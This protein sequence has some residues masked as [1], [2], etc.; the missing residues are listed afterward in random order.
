MVLTGI[1]AAS[2]LVATSSAFAAFT[3]PRLFASQH[4]VKNRV[5]LLYT[6]STADDPVAKIVHYI[7]VPYKTNLEARP[8]GTLVGTVVLR[9]NLS[10]RVVDNTTGNMVL[11]GTITAVRADTQYTVNG[12]TGRMSEAA[13]ACTGKPLNEFGQYWLL[14]LKDAGGDVAWDVPAFAERRSAATV[15]GAD[16]TV[17]VCFAP[18]DV[19]ATSPNRTPG[20]FKVRELDLRLTKVFTSPKDGLQRFSTLATP[21]TPKTGRVNEGGT[22]EAQSIVSYPRAVSIAKPVRV[23]LTNGYATFRFGGTVSTPPHDRGR[24]SL[25]R[26]FNRTD[27]GGRTAKA[28]KIRESGRGNYTRL[29]TIKR[30]PKAQN[31]WFQ[32][33]SYV[34]TALY[35]EKGCA[36]N[37]HPGI[38]CIQTTRAGYMV[39]SRNVMVRVPAT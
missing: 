38:T 28:F 2:A 16:A 33:R 1:V 22:V 3:T 32:V 19:P 37:Y 36:V 6:Q 7:P 26:G 11:S 24:I 12:K 10:D 35:G 23:K 27:V 20:G 34:P 9:G 18:S 25:F 15:F 14:R 13:T 8:E 30:V 29:H 5:H 17:S 21:Y 31:F 39:R 4:E